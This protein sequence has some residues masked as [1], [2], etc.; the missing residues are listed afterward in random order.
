MF[1]YLTDWHWV[2]VAMT[3][4]VMLCALLH[5]RGFGNGGFNA[6]PIGSQSLIHPAL[7]HIIW[8]FSAYTYHLEYLTNIVH[9]LTNFYLPIIKT[10]LWTDTS[11]AQHCGHIC[12]CWSVVAF[13]DWQSIKVN[14]E[15]IVGKANL[16]FNLETRSKYRHYVN[17]IIIRNS[18][19]HVL[20]A[21]R[22]YF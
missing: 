2:R 1:Y 15:V 22:G 12:T 13:S 21:F 17:S 6:P 8:T 19:M 14:Q 10:F 4:Y 9:Q 7:L 18:L 16:N 3:M 20:R 11:G 5:I